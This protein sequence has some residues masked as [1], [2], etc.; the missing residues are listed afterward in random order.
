L[1]PRSE[2]KGVVVTVVDSF[3]DRTGD[4]WVQEPGWRC[5]LGRQGV[6]APLDQIRRSPQATSST[7]WAHRRTEFRVHGE[8]PVIY[9]PPSSS[10]VTRHDDEVTKVG[11]GTSQAPAD[12]D[13]SAT[14]SRYPRNSEIRME[15][16]EGV[17]VKS[18]KAPP[19]GQRIGTRS[20]QPGP[21]F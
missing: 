5:V 10:P 6:R 18:T 2:L 15:K 11:T 13:A 4:I 1:N 9:R 17:L 16:W 19:A 7:S 21:G 3:A 12:V 14:P 8:W 20:Q